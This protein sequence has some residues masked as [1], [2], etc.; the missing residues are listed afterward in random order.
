MQLVT[1]YQNTTTPIERL[2]FLL[3]LNCGCKQ[4]EV[5]TITLGEVFLDVLHPYAD[6]LGFQSSAN[7][8]SSSACD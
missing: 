5:G 7:D 4:A 1:L 3:G 2:L 8:P 6:M